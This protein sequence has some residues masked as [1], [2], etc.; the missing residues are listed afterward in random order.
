MSRSPVARTWKVGNHFIKRHHWPLFLHRTAGCGDGRVYILVYLPLSWY[1]G[2]KKIRKTSAISDAHQWGPNLRDFGHLSQFLDK[3]LPLCSYGLTTRFAKDRSRYVSPNT[4]GRIKTFKRL[5]TNHYGV[6]V[7]CVHVRFLYAPVGFLIRFLIMTSPLL[8]LDHRDC[9]T[10]TCSSPLHA[11]NIYLPW[12]ADNCLASSGQVTS[13]LYCCVY[14]A[15][16]AFPSLKLGHRIKCSVQ[17]RTWFGGQWQKIRF[18]KSYFSS[19]TAIFD[20]SAENLADPALIL[21]TRTA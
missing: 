17:V 1:S 2:W 4:S 12:Q 15:C 11:L 16:I 9:R 14:S 18:W 7:N 10:E 21:G 19:T 20:G 13:L 3:H 6:T 8:F 5:N